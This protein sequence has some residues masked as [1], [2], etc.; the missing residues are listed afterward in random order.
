MIFA[1]DEE[2]GGKAEISLTIFPSV[3][4]CGTTFRTIL[5]N[6][7]E[8]SCFQSFNLLY[9][10]SVKVIVFMHSCIHEYMKIV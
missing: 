2:I 3:P 6:E 4:L 7:S 9:A 10:S 1:D 8:D 5:E